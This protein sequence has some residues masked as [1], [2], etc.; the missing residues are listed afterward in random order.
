MRK[1]RLREVREPAQGHGANKRWGPDSPVG[2]SPQPQSLLLSTLKNA[3]LD[4]PQR[5]K[6]TAGEV[7]YKTTLVPTPRNVCASAEKGL[8]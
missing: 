6:S 4:K 5:A 3:S 2:L 7:E 1:L 8:G